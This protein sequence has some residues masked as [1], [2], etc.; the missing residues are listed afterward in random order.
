MENNKSRAS[1]WV[2]NQGVKIYPPS[3]RGY[4]RIVWTED[5]KPRDTSANQAT[6]IPQK[7]PIN[8]HLSD[9]ESSD[10][11]YCQTTGVK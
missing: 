7:N 11:I 9:H 8:D 2:T 6:H 3:S 10:P 4:W 1:K 5:G